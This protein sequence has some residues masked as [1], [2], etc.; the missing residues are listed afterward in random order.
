MM[1]GQ[2][3]MV[4][5]EEV[6]IGVKVTTNLKPAG[7]CQRA[8]KTAQM[9]LGQLYLH[10]QGHTRV[11]EAVCKVHETAPGICRPGMVTLV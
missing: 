5:E 3:M 10:I 4:T 11:H 1:N 6:D 2:E 9:V 8:A 7:Q